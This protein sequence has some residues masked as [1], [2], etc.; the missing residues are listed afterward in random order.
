MR[1]GEVILTYPLRQSL[2]VA[3]NLVTGQN[4]N[5][6]P[7]DAR[8]LM[9]LLI[10]AGGSGLDGEVGGRVGNGDL[11]LVIA[12]TWPSHHDP[13]ERSGDGEPGGDPHG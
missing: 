9:S 6:A 12:S 10:A 1:T 2:G 3:G 13:G 7:M 5:A 4:R 11:E 8:E